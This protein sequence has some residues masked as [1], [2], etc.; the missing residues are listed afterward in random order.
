[1]RLRR[2]K[3]PPESVTDA[4]AAAALKLA[5][6]TLAADQLAIERYAGMT[7]PREAP[8]DGQREKAGHG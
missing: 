7:V 5:R 6:E 4:Q 8:E 2:R 3:D 1:M